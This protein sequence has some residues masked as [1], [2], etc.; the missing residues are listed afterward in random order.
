MRGDLCWFFGYVIWMFEFCFYFFL[1]VVCGYLVVRGSLELIGELN[2]Y[3][4]GRVLVFLFLVLKVK[5]FW[6]VME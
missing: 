3:W 2:W 1:E 4:E 6:V 5:I